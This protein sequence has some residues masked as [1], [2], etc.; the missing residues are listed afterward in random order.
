MLIVDINIITKYKIISV[1]VLPLPSIFLGIFL[2]LTPTR[3]HLRLSWRWTDAH[4]AYENVSLEYIYFWYYYYYGTFSRA[5]KGTCSMFICI[6]FTWKCNHVKKINFQPPQSHISAKRA[7][8]TYILLLD[9]TI[10]LEKRAFCLS[11]RQNTKKK[12][13]PAK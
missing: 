11:E 2:S 1:I 12:K 5:I 13:M 7:H 8:S 9:L 6:H 10:S 3:W 4:G